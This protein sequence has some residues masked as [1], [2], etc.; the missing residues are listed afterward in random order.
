MG[1]SVDDRHGGAVASIAGFPGIWTLVEQVKVQVDR[2][3]RLTLP[4]P[5]RMR[6]VLD[7]H[8]AI[9]AAIAA[10]DPARAGAAMT[11]HLDG[12]QASI[13]NMRDLN[14]GYFVGEGP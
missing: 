12:L 9:I 5:G 11:A 1:E 10:R 13:A 3:R 8:A 6:M 2:F 4:V 7:E 14:P